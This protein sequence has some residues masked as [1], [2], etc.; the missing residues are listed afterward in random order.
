MQTLCP[1]SGSS[2]E[3]LSSAAHWH[4]SHS[5]FLH[6]SCRR[7]IAAA[8]SAVG[9]GGEGG[10][11]GVQTPLTRHHAECIGEHQ[12]YAA[13]GATP[14]ELQQSAS[15]LLHRLCILWSSCVYP[16]MSCCHGCHLSKWD[17][18]WSLKL[19][20]VRKGGAWE[21]VAG[22]VLALPWG[23]PVSW[24][25]GGQKQTGLRVA[26]ELR[27]RAAPLKPVA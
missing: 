4:A 12:E 24:A 23:Q 18:L 1:P 16:S 3:E 26:Q 8:A 13:H 7:R 27:A 2:H 9:E 15:S 25:H 6:Q 19:Y 14:A 11:G 20:A 21:C 10:Q 22:R 5:H 17:G